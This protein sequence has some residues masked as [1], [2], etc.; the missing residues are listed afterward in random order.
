MVMGFYRKN[1]RLKRNGQGDSAKRPVRKTRRST[2]Q[3]YQ[4]KNVG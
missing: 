1:M 4:N 2:D 3:G